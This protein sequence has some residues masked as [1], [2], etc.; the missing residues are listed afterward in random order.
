MHVFYGVNK[1]V[2]DFCP[3]AISEKVWMMTDFFVKTCNV[4]IFALTE[5]LNKIVN[6][7]WIIW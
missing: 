1:P 7:G 2:V 6:Y 4:F 5:L 3:Y